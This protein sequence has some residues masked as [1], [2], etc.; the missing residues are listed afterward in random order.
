MK[1]SEGFPAWKMHG[2]LWPWAQHRASGS[3]IGG[4]AF[5]NETG[6]KQEQ[7]LTISVGA[8]VSRPCKSY[9]LSINTFDF[10]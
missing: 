8:R 10:M 6:W 1:R 4:R 2:F 9:L 5:S 3:W 7:A